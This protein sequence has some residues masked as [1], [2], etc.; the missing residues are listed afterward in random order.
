M[1][2]QSRDREGKSFASD[3]SSGPLETGHEFRT[4]QEIRPRD[5]GDT[6]ERL[7][8]DQPGVTSVR[9]RVDEES[10]AENE[11]QDARRLFGEAADREDADGADLDPARAQDPERERGMPRGDG[12]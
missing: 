11:Q 10:G 6:T 7:D 5:P 9:G 4:D 1:T 8:P 12:L 3:A 2:S